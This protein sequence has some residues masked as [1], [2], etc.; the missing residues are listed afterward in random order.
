MSLRHNRQLSLQTLESRQM[1]AADLELSFIDGFLSIRGDGDA[2]AVSVE[3]FRNPLT[4]QE[5]IRVSGLNGTTVNN[6]SQL[7][8][9]SNNVKGINIELNGGDDVLILKNIDSD[10]YA[11]NVN[12]DTGFGHDQVT[13]DRVNASGNVVI[14]TRAGNDTLVLSNL[15]VLGNVTIDLGVE[16]DNLNVSNSSMN[17]LAVLGRGG[18]DV[19]VLSQ[20]NIR[21]QLFA[22]LGNGDDE[23]TLDRVRADSFQLKGDDN[24]DTLTIKFDLATLDDAIRAFAAADEFE[25]IQLL[26]V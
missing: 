6:A 17:N 19:A 13:L 3:E 5:V 21:S 16:H 11:S 18:D 23:L 12:I 1:C 26:R 20:L 2:E 8:L 15:S 25:E 14:N 4:N 24:H 9:Q 22:D 10:V 7:F